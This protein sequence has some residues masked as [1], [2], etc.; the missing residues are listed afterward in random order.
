MPAVAAAPAAVQ[1]VLVAYVVVP[2]VAPVVTSGTGV[3]SS[4]KAKARS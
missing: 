4:S 2:S 3:S 1:P